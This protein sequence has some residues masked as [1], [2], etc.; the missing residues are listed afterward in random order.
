MYV[1]N[2]K[3]FKTSDIHVVADSQELFGFDLTSVQL[4]VVGRNSLTSLNVIEIHYLKA[5][6]KTLE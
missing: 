3:L 4:A 5:T 6:H 1:I 2:M